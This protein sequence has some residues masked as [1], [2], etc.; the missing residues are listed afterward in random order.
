MS[1]FA[2]HALIASSTAVV[3]TLSTGSARAADEKKACV[4]AYEQSQVL[5][6]DSKLSDAKKQLLI[7][8]R[9][10]CPQALRTDCT[11]WL[12]EVESNMP[13]VVFDVKDSGGKDVVTVRVSLDGKPL[14][15]KLDGKAMAVDPGA[16]TFKYETEGYPAIEEQVIV[17]QGEKNRK[18]AVTFKAAGDPKKPDL[19]PDPNPPPVVID[20]AKPSN[21]KTIA[22]V[23]GG[24]GVVALGVGGFFYLSGKGA[25]SDLRGKPC[26]ATKTCPQSDVDDVKSKY[27]YGDIAM[28]TG[29]AALGVGVVLYVTAPKNAEPAATARRFDVMPMPGGGFATYGGRF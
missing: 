22:Y 18:I 8:A 13:S 1:R 24:V 2:L 29:V 28:V 26:A 4:A 19:K 9:D 5:R 17:K 11:S 10:V 7:C 15:T 23:L 16:H 27:L 14:M 3:L 6:N 25:E 20:P 12:S 21:R